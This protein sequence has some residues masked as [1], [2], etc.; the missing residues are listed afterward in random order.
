MTLFYSSRLNFVLQTKIE[1]VIDKKTNNLSD[2]DIVR[3]ILVTKSHEKYGVLYD[4]YST[5]VYHKCLSFVKDTDKAKDLTHD[6]FLKV[7]I[8]LTKFSFKSK[9]STWLYSIT[10]N[11]CVDYVRKN[12]KIKSE[13]DETL[14]NISDDDDDANEKELFSIRA[15]RLQ[16]VLDLLASES[17]MLL[18]MKYQDDMSIA[19]LMVAFNL[20]ESTIKMRI[21]RAKAKALEMYNK[22]YADE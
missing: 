3:V 4:R 20:K 8:N 12:S 21:K 14:E 1:L 13:S 18:L 9:F 22:M 11:Y 7:F 17:K 6:V 2:E 19:D 15:K 16:K 5:R 10:Y